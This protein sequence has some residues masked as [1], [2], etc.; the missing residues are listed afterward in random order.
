[1]QKKM[2]R[3]TS[4]YYDCYGISLD[5]KEATVAFDYTLDRQPTNALNVMA[6]H[7]SVKYFIQ[8]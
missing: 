2:R 5:Y 1:M 6:V 7:I 8:G 3:L 4:N